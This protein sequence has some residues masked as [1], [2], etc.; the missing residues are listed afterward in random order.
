MPDETRGLRAA[1]PVVAVLGLAVAVLTAGCDE[2]APRTVV[3]GTLTAIEGGTVPEGVVRL[4]RPEEIE[5]LAEAAAG[6]DG[7]FEITTDLSGA[8]VARFGGE[9]RTSLTVPL[10]PDGRS[11]LEVTV[12]LGRDR[13]G[14]VAFTRPDSKQARLAI[15]VGAVESASSAGLTPA[16][17]EEDALLRSVLRLR[18]LQRAARDSSLTPALARRALE[19][20]PPDWPLWPFLPDRLELIAYAVERGR[21]SESMP[22]R[23]WD[24]PDL[25]DLY[26]EYLERAA[27]SHR[28]TS[29]PPAALYHRMRGAFLADRDS[30]AHR[31]LIA[32]L[33]GHPDSPWAERA[34]RLP[35]PYAAIA[36]G[37]PMPDYRLD[38]LDDPGR[39]YT[40]ERMLGRVYLMDFWATWCAPCI[41]EMENL[42][43]VYERYQGRGFEILSVNTGEALDLIEKFREMNWPMPWSHAWLPWPSEEAERFEL[44]GIPR[45]ILV[46]R[47][48]TILEARHGVLGSELER[49][50]RRAL[51]GMRTDEAQPERR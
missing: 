46:G 50:V 12:E 5:P 27:I 18:E 21:G 28:G 6:E 43:A 22:R 16:D 37:K 47:D 24:D 20:I 8:M 41:E 3:R 10:L 30:E 31:Y 14:R 49:M 33:N 2:A 34:K 19:E 23:V 38:S 13:S 35:D 32:L 42:H 17:E 9:G 40:R 25:F 15:L 1:R 39:P 29:V 48:G 44:P 36:P 51:E 11:E 4:H 26:M 7:R 45:T